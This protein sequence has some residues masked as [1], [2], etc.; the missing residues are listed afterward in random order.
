MKA[1]AALLLLLTPAMAAA[2]GDY[3]SSPERRVV[4]ERDWGP[5]LGPFRERL[6]PSLMQDF[7][8][9]YL[10]A[11]AN[12]ALPPPGPGE[13]RV[14]FLG[15]SITDKW[16][17]AAAFPGRPY[18]NRGIGSQ[19]TSQMVLR[20]HQDVIA[21]RPAAVVIL[22]GVNDL[23]G[24]MQQETPETIQ[25]N[26]EA[27]ADLADRHGIRIVFA[28]ILPIHNYGEAAAHVTQERS[29]E[30]LRA[31]NAWLRAFCEERSYV[32]ADYHAAFVDEHGLLQRDLSADG[33]H[34]LPAGYARMAP[35][36]QAAIERALS[37]SPPS[38]PPERSRGKGD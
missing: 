31:L 4:E 24:F 18:I 13:Q 17:L 37:G 30:T 34:P 27:M 6:V 3:Q 26:Y 12:R 33:I 1:L 35:I 14:V 32:F 11:E 16:N 22:A 19:V 9:R 23:H 20:F 5:W 25:A 28:S 36:A 10:Y 15:D 38:A 2:Q 7:G 8:E 21:L 29:P